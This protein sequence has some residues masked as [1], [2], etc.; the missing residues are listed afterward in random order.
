MV[1]TLMPSVSAVSCFARGFHDV[2]CKNAIFVKKVR[3]RGATSDGQS[4]KK[5]LYE[6]FDTFRPS[7]SAV[8]YFASG[9]HAKMPDCLEIESSRSHQPRYTVRRK[10]V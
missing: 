4:S 8:L 6:V 1:E 5:M 10:G 3:V 2:P 7:V 9:F